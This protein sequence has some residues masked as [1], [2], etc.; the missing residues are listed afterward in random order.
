M[1]ARPECRPVSVL[2]HIKG[3]PVIHARTAQMPVADL[4]SKRMDQV[5]TRPGERAET[6]DV[7]GILWNLRIEQDKMQHTRKVNACQKSGE[8]TVSGF[9][10]NGL[11]HY[12]PQL[13]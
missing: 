6:A 2:V 10:A 1:G 4:K 5:E 7:A 13:T 11:Q 8:P 9:T 12:L 3:T